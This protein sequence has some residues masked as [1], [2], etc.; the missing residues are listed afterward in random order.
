MRDTKIIGRRRGICWR[1]SKGVFNR[2][3]YMFSWRCFN[4]FKRRHYHF[5]RSRF[6]GIIIQT[7]Q[8]VTFVFMNLF[9]G[10]GVASV[11]INIKE[12]GRL[13]L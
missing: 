8:L 12:V 7:E 3:V 4:T 6:F 10:F 9:T 5:S 1:A 11:R 13:L 2:V